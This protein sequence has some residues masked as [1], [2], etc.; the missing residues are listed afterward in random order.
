MPIPATDTDGTFRSI[1]WAAIRTA[2][3]VPQSVDFGDPY[4]TALQAISAAS[5]PENDIIDVR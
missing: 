1:S 2:S 5:V 4:S 3:A